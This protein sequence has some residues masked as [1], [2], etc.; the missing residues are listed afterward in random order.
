[1]AT[2]TNLSKNI[3]TSTKEQKN[4]SNYWTNLWRD[5]GSG[6]IV[7]S[8]TIWNANIKPWAQALPWQLP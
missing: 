4:F 2:Y 5:F 3:S 1:M 7:G 8:P 6:N